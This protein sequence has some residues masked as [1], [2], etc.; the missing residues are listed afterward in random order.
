MGLEAS[1]LLLPSGDPNLFASFYLSFS[2]AA[3]GLAVCLCGRHGG[4]GRVSLTGCL[5]VIVLLLCY[6]SLWQFR[7]EVV[8][9][10]F[11]CVLLLGM[12]VLVASQPSS[13]NKMYAVLTGWAALMAVYGLL[14]QCGLLV[15]QGAAFPVK[16]AFDNP[17]GLGMF[18]ALLFPYVLMCR[19]AARVRWILVLL[20]GSAL[21]LSSSR[22]G[23]LA[24]SVAAYVCFYPSL[25][26]RWRMMLPV[27]GVLLLA[28]LY[29]CKPVSADGRMFVPCITSRLAGEHPWTG[30]GPFA[31]ESGYMLEQAAYF[32][33]HPASVWINVADNMKQPFNEYLHF[34]VRFG[35]AGTGWLLLCLYLICKRAVQ[36]FEADKRP[37]LASLCALAVCACF[38][39]PFYYPPV[40]LAAIMALG[41]LCAGSG[42]S[43]SF[44]KRLLGSATVLCSLGLSALSTVQ[45]AKERARLTLEQRVENDEQSEALLQEYETLSQTGYFHIHPAFQYNRAL[46]LYE[47]GKYVPCLSVLKQCKPYKHDYDW[48]MLYAYTQLHLDKKEAEKAFRVASCMLPGRLQP[49]YELVRLYD[50]T[51]RRDDALRCARDAVAISLKVRNERT[52]YLHRWLQD[53]VSAHSLSY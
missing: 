52:D 42:K 17:A 51:G 24:A 12:S 6:L 9:E 7:P 46:F 18:L 43:S 35:L 41:V 33:S 14:Q 31:F 28:G 36:T 37:A 44:P 47:C 2:A 11:T 53:Y 19:C 40:W 10:A 21:V 8:R 15:E 50:R 25:P 39:Y 27:A 48:Q 4:G 13:R 23:I 22:T 29:F 1:G 5:A 45:L 26:G 16:G 20:V 3:V 38:S 34:F 49:R 32:A 30:G